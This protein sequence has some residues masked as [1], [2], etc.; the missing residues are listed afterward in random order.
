MKFS[1]HTAMLCASVL[2]TPAFAQAPDE[3]GDAGTDTITVTAS[4]IPLEPRQIGSAIS[5]ISA[6]ELK[7]GQIT[8]LKDAL[9]DLPGLF[10]ST[11][12]HGDSTSISIR[13]SDHDQILWLIDGIRLG[14]PSST[15]TAFSAEHLVTRDIARVEVLRGNQSSLYGSDAIGG[16]I[17]MIT[18]RATEDGLKVNAELEGG[19]YG[20]V[21]GGA[22][23]LGKTGPLDFRLTATGYSHD[24]PS[25]ADPRTARPVGSATEDD[26][27]SR[28]G[29]SGR[30]GLAATDTLSLQVIGFWQKSASDLDGTRTDSFDTVRKREYAIG[31]QANYLSLDKSLKADASVSR[32]QARRLFYGVFNAPQGDAYIGTKDTANLNLGYNGGVFSVAAGGS[33]EREKTDQTTVFSGNF[34]HQIDTKSAYGEIALHP[35]ENLT[36][37][38]AARIDDNS[39]FGSFDTY[40]GTIAY[41]IEDVAGAN[42][43][44]LR[45]SYGSGAKAPG[46]YQLFDPTYGNPNLKVETSEGGDFGFDMIFDRFTAQ[47]TYFFTR[48]RN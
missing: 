18:Q 10:T 39:R 42:S 40:R 28:H 14:D 44:K 15:S 13:G 48:T 12:R 33:L 5:I 30:V 27:Y 21:N 20:T 29:V 38:G 17:N 41:V 32:Y 4:R 25:L 1:I 37:T 19:S 47:I 43:A 34:A 8:F 46:L 26:G 23:L 35:I 9:Q 22:S 2:A 6:E 45:A 11:D 3:G 36:V 31:A 24:G 7:G 16:V